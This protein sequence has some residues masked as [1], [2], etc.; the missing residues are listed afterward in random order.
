MN[1]TF[2]YTAPRKLTEEPVFLA[3]DA[4]LS[5]VTSVSCGGK[6]FAASPVD[7][8]LLAVL[9]ADAGET[10]TLS[11]ASEDCGGCTAVTDADSRTLHLSVGGNAFAD[12]VFDPAFPKPHLGPV[13]DNSGNSFTRCELMHKEHPHQ[14]SL[15][16]AIGN[17]NGVDCWNERADRCGY[18][19]NEE[20]Y[21]V[22]S[23]SAYAAFSARSRWTDHDDGR[24]MT[25]NTRF[26]VYNQTEAC[27]MLDLRITFTADSGDVVFGPT[28]EAGPLGIR[29]RDELRADIG[30]GILCN[31]R[32]GIG[33]S[34][35]WGKEA[36]WCDYHGAPEGIG[37][38]G[39]TVFDHP[40]N[41]RYPTAWH[42]R[43]YGLFAAN[44]LYF[45]GAYT[46]KAGESITYTYR[47]LFRRQTMSAD[48]LSARY[49]TYL[50]H[51]AQ[52]W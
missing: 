16:I 38:M 50:A 51:A 11:A 17:V 5:G 14:R 4:N 49:E 41:E 24:L 35:C 28:K 13:T 1:I 8:G 19:R 2:V 12:Y 47:I 7:G 36:E 29:L 39:V 30:Q 44:N 42:I 22:V 15:I 3:S 6:C 48:E 33:E 46:L 26:V 40:S 37:D 21:D 20:I 43:A 18:V 25:E 52:K 27:R 45:K 31:S 10:L 23:S 9:S 32:G 34:E